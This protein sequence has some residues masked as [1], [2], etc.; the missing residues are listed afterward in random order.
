[1]GTITHRLADDVRC[2]SQDCVPARIIFTWVAALP[3]AFAD[4][5][6]AVCG[7]QGSSSH[8]RFLS[9][10]GRDRGPRR[11]SIPGYRSSPCPD[12]LFGGRIDGFEVLGGGSTA[13]YATPGGSRRKRIRGCG[14]ARPVHFLRPTRRANRSAGP[15]GLCVFLE[16]GNYGVAHEVGTQCSKATGRPSPRGQRAV[17]LA[18]CPQGRGARGGRSGSAW[19]S[20]I[21]P[22]H[23]WHSCFGEEVDAPLLC[24]P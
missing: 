9:L 20:K 4:A 15:R 24:I 10:R 5:V 6:K 23:R 11:A 3:G 22:F 1:L 16:S 14:T 18:Q 19:S 17:R 13:R 8:Q 12:E 2:F 7:G 21:L